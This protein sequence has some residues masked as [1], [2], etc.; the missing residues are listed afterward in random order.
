MSLIPFSFH[1]L[2][3]RA[4]PNSWTAG[5]PGRPQPRS[6]REALLSGT[7][8]TGRFAVALRDRI[9][10]LPTTAKLGLIGLG[11]MVLAVPFAS[12]LGLN[13][14]P[15]TKG[16]RHGSAGID[17]GRK[18][19]VG[20]SSVPGTVPGTIRF[21]S[22]ASPV[23]GTSSLPGSEAPGGGIIGEPAMPPAV[24]AGAPRHHLRPLL[25]QPEQRPVVMPRPVSVPPERPAP[26]MVAPRPLIVDGQPRAFTPRPAIGGFTPWQRPEF[27]P[28]PAPFVGFGGPFF[29]F[30][31]GMPFRGYGGGRM[32]FFTGG[33]G[34]FGGFHG[35]R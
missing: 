1:A 26:V 3:S 32:P 11:A 12:L 31:G 8:A 2:V 14:T 29:R 35:R 20:T 4:P 22:A 23:P 15:A 10:S 28:R 34:S 9:G 17:S 24:I 5:A 16:V 7:A 19:P 30:G 25:P 21:P 13:D 27:T 18:P 6:W 33:G